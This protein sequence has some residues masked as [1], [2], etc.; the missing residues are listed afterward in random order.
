[1]TRAISA[2]VTEKGMYGSCMCTLKG[3]LSWPVSLEASLIGNEMKF[4][5]NDSAMTLSRTP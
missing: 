2:K 4:N 3:V 1:M 5:L